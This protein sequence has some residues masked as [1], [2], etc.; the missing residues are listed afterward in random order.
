MSWAEA[1]HRCLVLDTGAASS[2]ANTPGNH[3]P[4]PCRIAAWLVDWAAQRGLE[5]SQDGAGNVLITRPGS[6]GGED[7]PAVA[8][9]GAG[10]RAG[11]SLGHAD[12]A[13][14]SH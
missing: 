11:A 14:L 13:T 2:A 9:Q 4:L 12:C 5:W 7:A 1:L 10:G 8:L 3:L 6:G